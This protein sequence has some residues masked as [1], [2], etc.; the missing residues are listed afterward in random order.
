VL[1]ALKSSQG[2]AEVV[3]DSGG[4]I[5]FV[6]TAGVSVDVCPCVPPTSRVRSIETARSSW[7]CALATAVGFDATGGDMERRPG[8]S[9]FQG[10]V[11][12]VAELQLKA[13]GVSA[14]TGGRL[15]LAGAASTARGVGTEVFVRK[16]PLGFIGSG[17]AGVSQ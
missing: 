11:V 6:A 7:V 9:C 13:I 15:C 10:S 4:G 17:G 3:V 14:D 16:W 8:L 12:A 2:L 1:G 5:A